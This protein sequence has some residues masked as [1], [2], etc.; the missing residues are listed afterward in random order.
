MAVIIVSTIV[1]NICTTLTAFP[2]RRIPFCLYKGSYHLFQLFTFSAQHEYIGRVE[3]RI[4]SL[5][6]KTFFS[7]WQKSVHLHVKSRVG[8]DISNIKKK[9]EKLM[10]TP[11]TAF[12]INHNITFG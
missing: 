10:E 4:I 9:K 8:L 6:L 11:K 7:Q 2:N 5:K 12:I 1:T 3:R